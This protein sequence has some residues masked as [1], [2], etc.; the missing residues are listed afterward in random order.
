MEQK[1]P[2]YDGKSKTIFETNQSELVIQFFKDD[3]TA[4]NAQKKGTIRNKGRINNQTSSQIF[5]FLAKNQIAS[6]FVKKLSDREML[7]KKLA[8]IPVEIVVRNRAAGSICKRLG[9]EKGRPFS[10]PLV[11][12]FLKNDSL[13]D[14]LITEEH[15]QYFKWATLSELSQIRACALKVNQLLKPVFDSIGLE[16]VDFKLEF[17]R[18][19]KGDLLLADEVTLDGCRLWDKENGESMDKDRFRNDLGRV[20]EAYQEVSER[21]TRYFLGES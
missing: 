1:S 21:L 5:E 2:L 12:T 8:I 3:A 11:E 13:G 20:D 14:P 17:G 15:I 4:F 6:H 9:L 19:P 18:T 10:P 7:V 16:L